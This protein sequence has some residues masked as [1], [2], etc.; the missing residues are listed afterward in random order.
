MEGRIDVSGASNVSATDLALLKQELLVSL[1]GMH[2]DIRT[3]LERFETL[4]EQTAALDGRVSTVTDRVTTLE[5]TAVTRQE[6]SDQTKNRVAVIAVVVT[7]VST[8]LSSGLTT[9][10]GVVG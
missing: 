3:L 6:M 2:G 8:V 5:R 4:K 7:V 10:F 1:T 9:L